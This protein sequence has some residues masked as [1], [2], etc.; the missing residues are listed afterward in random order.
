M[1]NNVMVPWI[2]KYLP[3]TTKDII[4]QSSSITHMKNFIKNFKQL[5]KKALLIYGPSGSGKTSSVYA[6][7]NEMN[8]EILEVNASDFRNKDLIDKTIGQSSKQ[9]SLFMK[10]KLI[11]VDEVDGLSGTK[12]RG[13]IQAIAKIIQNTSFPIICTA[14]NPY[15]QKLSG[16]RSKC[17]LV[18]L[19]E[20]TYLNIFEKLKEICEKEK[21]KFEEIDLKSLSR[22]AA[23]DLR[24]AINDLQSLVSDGELK[25][26]D[27]RELSERDKTETII[28]ALVRVFKIKDAKVASAA[29]DNVDEDFDQRFLW[30][31]ANLPKEYTRPED[32]VRAYD[33]LSKADVY[34]GRIRRWQHWR[35]LV[36]V[37]CLLT[38]GVATAKD[39]KYKE[40]VKY[41]PTM[42]LLKIWQANMK[43]QKRKAIAAKIAEK[44][45]SSVKDAIKNTL[46]YM[47]VMMQK[48]KGMK[49]NLAEFFDLDK[50][51][52]AWMV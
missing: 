39:G 52:V 19:N 5:K 3:K 16:L 48:D 2:R 10:E 23:G 40:F 47:Q 28:D 12:D 50:E 44:T 33:A 27:V 21:V 31:D 24:A 1:R 4:G 17:E 38:A 14:T 37:N 18:G 25:K 41:A 13:G 20:L 22:R 49:T 36:Y 32:L 30:L 15:E 35:F 45:H 7:S 29:F 34:R 46:P 51:E 43:Y 42:R 11:L 9:Q 6:I 26:E 8:L